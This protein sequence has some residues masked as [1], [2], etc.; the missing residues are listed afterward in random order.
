MLISE[1][2]IHC[3][4]YE[5][6]SVVCAEALCCGTPVIAS[7]VGGIKEYIHNRNGILVKENNC[8]TYYFAINQFMQ[9][10]DFYDRKSI[11]NEAV[12]RFSEDIVG[13]LYFQTL[14]DIIN[15]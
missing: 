2:F 12:G 6:F 14:S 9:N 13:N 4:Q 8:E 11:S 10:H 5:T 15:A 3:S 7:D 1:A